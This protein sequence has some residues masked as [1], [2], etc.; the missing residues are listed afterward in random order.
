M[1]YRQQIALT[2]AHAS[3]HRLTPS[4]HS[5]S[6]SGFVRT[7]RGAIDIV[8]LGE[9]TVVHDGRAVLQTVRE[10]PGSHAAES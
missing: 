9:R 4:I 8:K 2:L 10:E 3:A 6:S 1:T 5:S 7:A